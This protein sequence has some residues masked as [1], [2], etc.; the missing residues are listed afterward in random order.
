[1]I[2]GLYLSASGVVTNSF[3][4]DVLA[5][6]IANSE[7][8]GFKRDLA[9]LQQRPTAA[10]ERG[11]T[12]PSIDPMLENIGGGLLMSRGT[13]DTTQG[14]F[15]PTGNNLDVGI[16][17]NGFF[18][19]AAGKDIHLTR[20]GQFLIDRTGQLALANDKGQAV[21]DNK[22]T[23]I[24]LDSTIPVNIATDGTVSQNGKV[25]AQLGLF[26]ISDPGRLHKD[27]GTLLAFPKGAT[28][29]TA[30]PT[31]RPQALERSNVEPAGELTQLM[32]TQRQ[33]EANAN[34]IHIQDETLDKLVNDVGKVS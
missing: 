12:D 20:N 16:D 24:Q 6:N 28:L 18:A 15:E 1:M 32:D 8:I 11:D 21:L 30:T 26:N 27:G 14:E 4:Q 23:P 9:N 17:G 7:T 31:L 10:V 13:V 29:A 2:Y 3:R 19:V 33:L 25:V 5:N 22:Q 34:M